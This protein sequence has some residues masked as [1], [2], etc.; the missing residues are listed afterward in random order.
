MNIQRLNSTV[1]LKITFAL[2]ECKRVLKAH[3]KKEF[4]KDL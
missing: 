2:N 1:N 4:Y 3:S